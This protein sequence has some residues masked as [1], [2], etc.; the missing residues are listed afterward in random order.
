MNALE[1]V[2][3]T[4]SCLRHAVPAAFRVRLWAPWW[5]LA[6]AQAAWLAAL[7]LFAHPAVAG[8]MVPLLEALAGPEVV[9]YPNLFRV[10][11]GLQAR[12]AFVVFALVGPVVAGAAALVFDDWFSGRPVAAGRALG[13]ALRRAP[14]LIVAQAPLQLVLLA[15]T[16]GLAA[17]LEVRGSSGLV[18]RVFTLASLGASIVAQA[19]FLYVPVDVMLGHRGPLAAWAEI[20]RAFGRAGAVALSLVVLAAFAGMPVQALAAMADRIVDRGRPELMVSVVAAQA[21]FGLLVAFVL[22]GASVLG[23]R[24]LIEPA[25]DES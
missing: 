4:G 3:F 6:G 13:A 7:V 17:W 21:A 8:L 19:V 22:A 15:L 20:P 12:G 16:F 14:A 25:E 9:H 10:L 1:Q 24:S 23:Y 5:P 18:V 11:P 2:L